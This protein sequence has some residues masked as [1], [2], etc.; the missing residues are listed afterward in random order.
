LII[1]RGKN[2]NILILNLVIGQSI[3]LFNHFNGVT[4]H[5][6]PVTSTT[7]VFHRVARFF[8]GHDTKTG[9]NVPNG[10]KISQMSVKYSKWPLNISTFSNLRPSKIYPN[11]DFWFEKKPSGNPGVPSTTQC[12]LQ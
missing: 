1:Q 3:S 11:W 2:D 4:K 10:H 9:K 8:L 12:M 6:W 5:L 7:F